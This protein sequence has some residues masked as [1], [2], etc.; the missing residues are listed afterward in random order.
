KPNK[1][2]SIFPS[3]NRGLHPP[4][5]DDDATTHNTPHRPGNGFLYEGGL[6]VPLIVRYPGTLDPGKESN[7]PIISTDWTPTL[8][9][10]CGIATADKFDGHDL[11]KA[12]QGGKGPERILFWH[13]P[14]YTNQ[15]GRPGGALRDGDFKLIENYED[16]S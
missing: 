15:G 7:V 3:G 12:L 4:E 10:L 13:F 1:A 5:G 11:S 8:L 6:R 9:A 2:I 16:G 14:H